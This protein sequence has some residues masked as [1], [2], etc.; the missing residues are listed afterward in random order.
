MTASGRARILVVDDEPDLR[1]LLSL[2]LEQM[3]LTPVTASNLDE[4]QQ[5]LNSEPIDVVLTDLRLPDG[6]GLELVDWMQSQA[7]TVPV[8]V[9]TAHGNV[10]SAV[11]ALKTGAFDFVAKPVDLGVLRRLTTRALELRRSPAARP[12]PALLGESAA[13][14]KL[15]E[16]IARVAR[17]QAPVLIRG[18]SGTG[19]ELVARLIHE[20]SPRANNPFVPVNCGA[21]PADLIESELFGHKKGAFTGANTDH[22]GLV[23]AAEGGTLFLDEVSELPEPLQVKLLRLIQERAVRPIGENR[24]IPV[25]VRF[26]SA[27]HQN[28][29]QRIRE[30]QFREDLYYRLDVITLFVPPLRDRSEDVVLLA[31]HFLKRF[32]ERAGRPVPDLSA[33]ALHQLRQH[34]WPGNVRE[35]ENVIERAITL[36]MD[37]YIDGDDIHLRPSGQTGQTDKALQTDAPTLPHL[38][39][40]ME[41]QAILKALEETGGNRTE[42]ARRLGVS[43]RQL[44]YRIEK[45]GLDR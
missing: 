38:L 28:L 44:R 8:A 31:Q 13:L 40:K 37:D 16:L 35:L 26:L 30:G 12:P 45:L 5:R 29:E 7:P 22:Q 1:E 2:T 20:S 17:S 27:T 32:A 10:D 41:R 19:K 23:R 25:D 24:E 14:L 34:S 39:E 11:S 18:E 9:I 15:R 3:D 4:A 43:F 36:T 42:A 33:E 6:T 21:I